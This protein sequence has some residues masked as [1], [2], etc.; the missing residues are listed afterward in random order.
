ML[1]HNPF[2][3]VGAFLDCLV[4]LALLVWV[5]AVALNS[6]MRLYLIYCQKIH[7]SFN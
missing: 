7:S 5:F 6:A 1:V 4:N 2:G 3:K